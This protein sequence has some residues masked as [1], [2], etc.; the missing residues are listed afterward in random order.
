M[1]AKFIPFICLIK[2][3]VGSRGE[4]ALRCLGE[5]T[6][7]RGFD[8]DSTKSHG[9]DECYLFDNELVKYRASGKT[10]IVMYKHDKEHGSCR[11]GFF[12]AN[13]ICY[14]VFRWNSN[15]YKSATVTD[16]ASFCTYH[17]WI[18]AEPR[19]S[20]SRAALRK[21][22]IDKNEVVYKPM[23]GGYD[24]QTNSGSM[25][26]PW[27]WRSDNTIVAIL[28]WDNGEPNYRHERCIQWYID[29]ERYNDIPCNNHNDFLCQYNP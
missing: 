20:Q 24:L 3:T 23:L 28:P 16:A 12:V 27:V 9:V 26:G 15:A 6:N 4:C 7:C 2:S 14:H 29:T 25:R 8:V 21:Y 1:F 5:G 11:F 13:G 17:G 19:T 22:L 18:L 10:K